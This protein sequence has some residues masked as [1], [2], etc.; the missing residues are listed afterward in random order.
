VSR[1]PC[2][3]RKRDLTTAVNAVRAAG[4]TVYHVEVHKDGKIVIV[5]DGRDH[6]QRD[7]SDL[8]AWVA[9]H[10]CNA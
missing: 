10:A 3:F 4:C 5:T 8:D 9:K 6:A 2:T 1:G 7:E